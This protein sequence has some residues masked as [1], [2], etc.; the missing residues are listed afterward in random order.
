MQWIGGQQNTRACIKHSTNQIN[1]VKGLSIFVSSIPP[2]TNVQQLQKLAFDLKNS[3][4]ILLPVWYKTLTT[5]HL[6]PCMMPYDVSTCWNSTFD[7]LEFAIQY[8][9]AIDTMTT[10]RNFGLYQYEL[11]S[12]EWKIAS[13]LWDVLKVSLFL[14]LQY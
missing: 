4:T 11:L 14:L 13:E 12:T 5:H 2:L 1:V 3:T 6:S 9:V 7:M 10:A 8:H